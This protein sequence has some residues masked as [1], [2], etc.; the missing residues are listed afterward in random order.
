M[1]ITLYKA[2]EDLRAVLDQVDPDTGEMSEAY[3]AA[4]ELVQ[5]KAIAVAAYILNT[6]RE[7]RMAQ[8][9]VQDVEAQL[10]VAERRAKALRKMLAEHMAAL[11]I[12]EVKDGALLSAKLDI[13][14]DVSVDVFD[15]EQL[16]LDCTVAKVTRNPNKAQIRADLEAGKDVPG[17]RLNRSNRLTL[18]G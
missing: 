17:A 9:Y 15:K 4:R 7:V 2:A 3:T 6:E 13:E 11:G 8:D 10:D 14:R 18:K 1:S 12:K 16:P 5:H